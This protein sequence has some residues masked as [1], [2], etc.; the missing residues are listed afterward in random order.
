MPHLRGHQLRQGGHLLRALR[1]DHHPH[2]ALTALPQELLQHRGRGEAHSGRHV[3][4]DR[5]HAALQQR[6]HAV[7]RAQPGTRLP[8]LELLH[9]RHH[10][11]RG[12]RRHR[13]R[14]H[15]GPLLLHGNDHRRHHHRTPD[16]Q[17]TDGE[18]QQAVLLRP[19]VLRAQNLLLLARAGVRRPA[20][21]LSGRVLPRAVPRGPRGRQPL[22]RGTAAGS[23]QLRDAADPRRPHLLKLRVIPGRERVERQGP[24]EGQG[25]PGHSDLHNDEQVFLQP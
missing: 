22:R 1:A 4:Q 13:P 14:D 19:P 10:H 12:L 25:G 7:L 9:A 23:P 24:Q 21:L 17:R 20:L 2:P 8:L 11:H 3:H 6:G 15:P 5:G 16:D 18:D